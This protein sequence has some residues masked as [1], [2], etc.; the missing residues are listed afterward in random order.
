MAEGISSTPL[1]R[2]GIPSSIVNPTQVQSGANCPSVI[3]GNDFTRLMEQP[4]RFRMICSAE[5]VRTNG[6]K[7][8]SRLRTALR[9]S[10]TS[11]NLKI[12]GAS[13]GWSES[14]FIVLQNWQDL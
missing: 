8:M 5:M 6:V 11:E 9:N 14:F 13:N 12:C 4:G 7:S 3:L 1:K 10:S 2:I